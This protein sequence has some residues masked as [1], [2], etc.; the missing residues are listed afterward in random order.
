M[1]SKAVAL[2]KNPE[3]K[4]STSLKLVEPATLFDR[5]NRIHDAIERRAFEIFD[6]NGQFS[7]VNLMT[8]SRPKPNF[9]IPYTSRFRKPAMLQVEAEVPGFDAKDLE[10]SV[11]P[12]RLTISGKKETTEES[13]K[14]NTVYKEQCSNEIL[15]VVDLPAE[16]ETAKA[17]ATLEEWRS[18]LDSA[19]GG[20]RKSTNYQGGSEARLRHTSAKQPG[21][22]LI[23][24]E[25]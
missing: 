20:T 4:E 24:A 18:Q 11:E 12:E 16:V 10:V 1:S 2:E 3:T 8:G 19:E 6:W 23:L 13:K 21:S 9:F 22:K 14:G 7:A 25:A 5:M 17:A 15:R